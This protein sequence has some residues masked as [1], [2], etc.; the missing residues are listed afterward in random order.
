MKKSISIL[1]AVIATL[2]ILTLPT[3]RISDLRPLS[4]KK[5]GVNSDKINTGRLL[6]QEALDSMHIE[7][8]LK[9]SSYELMMTDTWEK[10][11]GISMNPWPGTNGARIKYSAEFNTF[12]SRAEWLEG[13]LKGHILGIQSWQLYESDSTGTIQKIADEPKKK[14]ILPTVQYFLELPYRLS[15]AT[16]ITYADTVS[17]NGSV[18]DCILATW[19]KFEPNNNDQ[20]LLFINKKTK[21]I[22]R[23]TY[24]I[25]DNYM[26][27]PRNF[28]GSAYF[29]DFRNVQDV[30]IPFRMDV[31]PFDWNEKMKVHTMKIEEMRLDS[32]NTTLLQPFTDLP[33]MGDEKK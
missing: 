26:T 25:R 14:F 9:Y 8:W 29:S 27:T 28:Y 11:M 13:D 24:T 32:I 6:L 17:W 18:Y 20:Y 10:Q 3:C 33:R 2:T 19:E 23:V 22:D 7:K 4:I 31:Y 5:Q 30:L 1:S 15:N 16:H 21:R 12:N